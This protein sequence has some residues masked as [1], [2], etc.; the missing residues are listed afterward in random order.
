[1]TVV[2]FVVKMILVAKPEK[3]SDYRLKKNGKMHLI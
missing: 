2:H 1:M 3:T